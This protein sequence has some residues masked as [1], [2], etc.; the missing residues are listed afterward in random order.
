ME[1]HGAGTR[2]QKSPKYQS[3]CTGRTFPLFFPS[4]MLLALAIG[5]DLCGDPNCIPDCCCRQGQRSLEK[6][7]PPSDASISHGCGAGG[8]G[9]RCHGRLDGSAAGPLSLFLEV[10][11]RVYSGFGDP[12][13]GAIGNGART[14]WDMLAKQTAG[15]ARAQESSTICP[16]LGCWQT[17][18]FYFSFSAVPG[19]PVLKLL[20]WSRIIKIEHLHSR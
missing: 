20:S 12:Y 16:L 5:V 6:K 17:E 14:S 11:V 18:K 7:A 1:T 19:C 2:G 13:K 3:L 9:Q 10:C 8:P 4:V 15:T